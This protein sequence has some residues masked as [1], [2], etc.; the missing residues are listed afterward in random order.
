M[1][2]MGI[3]HDLCLFVFLLI[4]LRLVTAAVVSPNENTSAI[5]E[6]LPV[7]KTSNNFSPR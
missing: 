2:L 6:L 3:A 7:F 5:V 1:V 4:I